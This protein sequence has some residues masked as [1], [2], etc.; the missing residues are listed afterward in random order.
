MQIEHVLFIE[1]E[2]DLLD[3][4][5]EALSAGGYQVTV[6]RN[7]REALSALHGP[8][9]FSH[10]ITDVSMPEGVSGL[11]IATQALQHQP[12]ARVVVVSGYQ[13]SQL[14][15]LPGHVRFLPKPYR[16]RQLL[17]VLQEN[18]A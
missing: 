13:R 4:M 16:I 2:E 1:D 10:V 6:V 7:G 11:E 8:E 15:P 18:T 12:Q 14:P 17:A 9:R 3:M 5:H